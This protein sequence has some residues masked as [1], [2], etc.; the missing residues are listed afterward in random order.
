MVL[1]AFAMS[2]SGIRE[3]KR[4]YCMILI[5]WRSG[6]DNGNYRQYRL[7]KINAGKPDST[8]LRC[9]GR[10][11]Y[12]GRKRY[13]KH[14]HEGAARRDWLCAAERRAVLGN[15]R[16][17]LRFGK[18]NATDA[19]SKKQQRLRRQQ[20]LLKQKMINMR[21]RFPRAEQMC[22]ADRKQRL[23]IARAIAKDPKIFY[24]R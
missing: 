20:S 6:K 18:E 3:R 9:D 8:S 21:P 11:D 15:D 19:R 17:D 16:I 10:T 2:I 7:R 24:F 23:A 22:P 4:M 1:F 13:P 14:Y 5:S 12:P